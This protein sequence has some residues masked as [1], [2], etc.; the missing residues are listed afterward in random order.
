MRT[1][2][3]RHNGQDTIYCRE[4]SKT[5]HTTPDHGKSARRRERGNG[6]IDDYDDDDE[7]D[8]TTISIISSRE[9]YE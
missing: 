5:I 1:E 3:G 6:N 7:D 2:G 9:D 8:V 4:T